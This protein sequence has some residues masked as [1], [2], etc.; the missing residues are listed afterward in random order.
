[1]GKNW[2]KNNNKLYHLELIF[3]HNISIDFADDIVLI[4]EI[5]GE[6]FDRLNA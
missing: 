3:A 5:R 4:E 6:G 1:M 2:C